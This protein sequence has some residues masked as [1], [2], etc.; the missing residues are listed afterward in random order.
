MLAERNLQ[1]RRQGVWM[2]RTNPASSSKFLKIKLHIKLSILELSSR[3]TYTHPKVKSYLSWNLEAAL[4][5]SSHEQQYM[6]YLEL[7]GSVCEMVMNWRATAA[8]I[9]IWAPQVSVNIKLV[10]YLHWECLCSVRFSAIRQTC[11][12]SNVLEY[13]AVL[14][15]R[16]VI[17]VRIRVA[18]GSFCVDPD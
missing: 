10:I 8:V 4:Y 2:V 9:M 5:D 7:W 16:E 11:D 3:C 12:V 6:W 14:W 17:D 13:K 15:K 18:E 1:G